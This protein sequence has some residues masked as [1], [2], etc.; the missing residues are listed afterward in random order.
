MAVE[1]LS[2]VWPAQ[3]AQISH[4][5]VMLCL[6]DAADPVQGITWLP[7]RSK[8][9]KL[10]MIAKTQLSDRQIKRALRALEAEGWIERFENPGHGV[11]FRVHKSPISTASQGVTPCPPY[12]D[13]T[14]SPARGDTMSNRDDTMSPKT[15]NNRNLKK[16]GTGGGGAVDNL[17]ADR[18][19]PASLEAW[20][21]RAYVDVRAAIGKP[22]TSPVAVLLLGKL[23]AIEAEGWHIGDV[24][25]R[26]I[27]NGWTDF[28]LPTPG[29]STG[30]R[31]MVDGKPIK[32]PG[33]SEEEMAKAAEIDAL[34]DLNDRLVERAALFA[35]AERKNEA[36]ALG[37]LVGSL[38]IL[39]G[40]NRTKRKEP[41]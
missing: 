33:L 1:F 24:V 31:R 32:G 8:R 40:R 36:T 16:Q 30:V 6:A 15:E 17:L 23:E 21:W 34:E 13:D 27:V 5:M 9:G 14:M 2:A 38:P 41:K 7:I 20:Q 19:L 29:R 35:A 18:D 26:A 28:H 3:F 25:E 22:L 37:D 11:L 12:R 39:Q 4:K 10:D